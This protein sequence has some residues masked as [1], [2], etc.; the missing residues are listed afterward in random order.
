ML[1][2]VRHAMTEANAAGLVLG[3]RDSPLTAEGREMSRCL[4]GE[5]SGRG[6]ALLVCSPLGRAVESAGILGRALGLAPCVL[7]G[8]TELSCGSWEG[9]PRTE[10]LPQG[11]LLR[12]AWDAR[13]P[14]GESCEDAESRVADALKRLGERQEPSGPTLLVGHAVVN[15]VVLSLLS[16]LP[17]PWL[18]V[19]TQPHWRVIRVRSDRVPVWLDSGEPIAGEEP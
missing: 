17:R 4:A 11:G 9:R 19:F 13:P 2:L 14:G 18:N 5:L 15:R 3:R 12:L 1:Y 6:L 10:L 16:G 8:L 7:P